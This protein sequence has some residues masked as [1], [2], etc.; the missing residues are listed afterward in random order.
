VR[1]L[2]LDEEESSPP[3]FECNRDFA[4]GTQSERRASPAR[5]PTALSARLNST[6]LTNADFIPTQSRAMIE[7]EGESNGE[8][9]FTAE[10]REFLSGGFLRGRIELYQLPALLRRR[11]LHSLPECGRYVKLDYVS[12]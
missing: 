1:I 12:H 7:D 4:T 5:E 11:P 9:E 8:S 2:I 3:H 6:D 10:G